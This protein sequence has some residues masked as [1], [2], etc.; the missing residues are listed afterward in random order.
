MNLKKLLKVWSLKILNLKLNVLKLK[1]N[2]LKNN[3][4]M[5]KKMALNLTLLKDF[6]LN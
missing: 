2:N 1:L 4:K 3:L 5:Q 6:E